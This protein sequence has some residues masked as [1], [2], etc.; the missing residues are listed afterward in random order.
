MFLKLMINYTDNYKIINVLKY[1]KSYIVPFNF[2]IDFLLILSEATIK[3]I[4]ENAEPKW[5]ILSLE[6][7]R[8]FQTCAGSQRTFTR[9][10]T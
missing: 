5:V 10:R 7:E 9:Q 6:L 1:V 8:G 2:L 3:K 4:R